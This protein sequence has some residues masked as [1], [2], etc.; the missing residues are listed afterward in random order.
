MSGT[1]LLVDGGDLHRDFK[2]LSRLAIHRN[3]KLYGFILRAAV[4]GQVHTNDVVGVVVDAVL[5]L[6]RGRFEAADA[7]AP[8][9]DTGFRQRISAYSP[10]RYLLRSRQVLLHQGG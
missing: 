10:P 3:L 4:P 8:R 7:I 5:E 2:R 1:A 9:D 6:D